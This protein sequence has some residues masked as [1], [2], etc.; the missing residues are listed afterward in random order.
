MVA[1]LDQASQFR[2]P[3]VSIVTYYNPLWQELPAETPKPQLEKVKHWL[4]IG[5]YGYIT[6]AVCRRGFRGCRLV[7]F[8]A[9]F[10]F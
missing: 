7:P 1:V 8:A 4:C 5:Q 9:A 10:R 6:I 3:P 2:S